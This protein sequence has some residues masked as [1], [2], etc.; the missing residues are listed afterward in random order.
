M[1]SRTGCIVTASW[2]IANYQ[3]KAAPG[4]SIG[5][6]GYMYP[7]IEVCDLYNGVPCTNNPTQCCYNEALWCPSPPTN[8]TTDNGAYPIGDQNVYQGQMTD[9]YAL[10]PFPNTIFWNWATIIILCFGNLAALDFQVRCI[11]AKDRS[12]AKWGC[13]VAGLFTLV[14]AIPFSYLGGITRYVG[15]RSLRSYRLFSVHK[16]SS[17]YHSPC[18]Y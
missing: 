17:F 13:F 3:S 6:P 4:P 18:L 10:S 12:T 5:F 8:C 2:L 9:P 15:Y 16:D 14:V 11:A 7:N 1:N